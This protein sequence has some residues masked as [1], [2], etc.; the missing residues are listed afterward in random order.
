MGALKY[1]MKIFFVQQKLKYM[2]NPN[3]ETHA[4]D[5]SIKAHK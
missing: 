4:L 1:F 3:H 5:Y 2:L